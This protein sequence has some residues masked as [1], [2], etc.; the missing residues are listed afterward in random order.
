MNKIV[1]PSQPSPFLQNP[2]AVPD[3]EASSINK[4]LQGFVDDFLVC[5]GISIIDPLIT[6]I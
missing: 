3:S 4:K 5:S 1:I 6:A 2:Q